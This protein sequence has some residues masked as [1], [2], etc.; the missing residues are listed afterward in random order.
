MEIH[1]FI[2]GLYSRGFCLKSDGQCF[3]ISPRARLTGAD[4][5]L[6][7]IQSETLATIIRKNSALMETAMERLESL[8]ASPDERICLAACRLV[9]ET[10]DQFRQLDQETRLDEI[11]NRLTSG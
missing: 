1:Q 7:Q 8:L 3:W 9:F 6:R 5:A 10:G 11:L 4:L 2:K